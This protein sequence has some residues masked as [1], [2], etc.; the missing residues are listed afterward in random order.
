MLICWRRRKRMPLARRSV[1]PQPSALAP[2]FCGISV[3]FR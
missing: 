1:R 3:S 2:L